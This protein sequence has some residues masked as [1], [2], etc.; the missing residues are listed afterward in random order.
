MTSGYEQQ[1]D[2]RGREVEPAAVSAARSMSRR[3]RL[4]WSR[5]RRA[6]LWT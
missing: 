1:G 6:V 5:L 4:S 3:S 2:P